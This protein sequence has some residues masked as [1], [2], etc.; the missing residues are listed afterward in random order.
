MNTNNPKY[1]ARKKAWRLKNKKSRT[2]SRTR[3]YNKTRPKVRK[4]RPW[5][6]FEKLMIWDT[7][8]TDV[9]LCHALGRSARAI[10]SMRYKMKKEDFTK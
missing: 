2:A 1:K 3:N 8:L 9:Y 10:Q 5:G 6:E 4:H 7:Q